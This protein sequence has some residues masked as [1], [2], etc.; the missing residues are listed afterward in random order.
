MSDVWLKVDLEMHIKNICSKNIGLHAP[1]ILTI[2]GSTIN[3]IHHLMSTK[4]SL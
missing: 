1:T 4:S 3:M 2:L